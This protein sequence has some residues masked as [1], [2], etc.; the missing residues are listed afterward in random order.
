MFR[1]STLVLLLA[2]IC[3]A[4]AREAQAQRGADAESKRKAEEIGR[5]A[6]SEFDRGRESEQQRIARAKYEGEVRINFNPLSDADRAALAPPQEEAARFGAF[7]SQPDTGLVRLM[8][9]EKFEG[10]LGVRGDGVYYSFAHLTH[11]YRYG[12]DLR[13]EQEHFASS[14]GGASYGFLFD[15]GDMALEDVTD[16]TAPVKFLASFEPPSAEPDAR[17]IQSRF[18]DGYQEGWFVYRQ[19]VPAVVGHTYV[20]RS[21]NYHMSD[22]LVAFRV[23]RKDEENGSMIMLWKMLRRYPVPQLA[24]SVASKDVP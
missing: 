4:C 12:S 16:E 2:L 14:L 22:V 20:V 11:E 8:P 18:Q 21:V 10:K 19:R 24:R 17:K 9:R 15:L 23:L 13:L 1:R 3:G 6:Q 5:L 7:L